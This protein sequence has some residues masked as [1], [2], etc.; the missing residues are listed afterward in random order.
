LLLE[1][2]G[3]SGGCQSARKSRTARDTAKIDYERIVP[4]YEA[5]LLSLPGLELFGV[6][7]VLTKALVL[8]SVGLI[9]VFA[10][11]RLLDS[12]RGNMEEGEIND[13]IPNTKMNVSS[14][15]TEAQY[16][17]LR[18]L[19]ESLLAKTSSDL[20]NDPED[21]AARFKAN[22]EIISLLSE[23]GQLDGQEKLEE[24]VK[25]KIRLLNLI[26]KFLDYYWDSIPEEVYEKL[27]HMGI[28]FLIAMKSITYVNN[29][30]KDLY[31]FY[32]GVVF[33]FLY[34]LS[35]KLKESGYADYLLEK[36]SLEGDLIGGFPSS[37]EEKAV[38][39][40]KNIENKSEW[41]FFTKRAKPITD[42]E[43]EEYMKK[44]GLS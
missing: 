41:P 33:S 30:D 32:Q 40:I 23:I 17:E 6:N 10:A 12:I 22:Q 39:R 5:W 31:R 24:R 21:D 37:A 20:N 42:E 14:I 19:F 15:E 8:V 38:E 16:K 4:K 9:V 29:L 3:T 25:K 26:E 34:K 1:Y 44:R 35:G 2:L 11:S 36:R 27:A 43:I 7:P 18:D 13:P 28:F